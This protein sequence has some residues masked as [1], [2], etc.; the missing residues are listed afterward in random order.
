MKCDRKRFS[1][2]VPGR[3]G[4]PRSRPQRAPGE[5]VP[6]GGEYG[7]RDLPEAGYQAL[8]AGRD[9]RGHVTGR[10]WEEPGD[11]EE[12]I[13]L[14]VAQLE[15]PGQRRRDLGGRPPGASLLQAHEV[16]D[17]H[18]GQRGEFLTPQARRPPR[19][20]GGKPHVD[21]REA[22]APR[23]QQRSEVTPRIPHRPSLT[24]TAGS[25]VV[26]P[27]PLLSR[28]WIIRRGRRRLRA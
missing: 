24:V 1:R 11:D 9:V 28:A 25:W 10:G 12:V 2:P 17:A 20:A 27:V 21:G 15:R 3:A 19:I 5:E 6:R 13:P 7:Q 26:L 8:H 18:I 22:V 23:A 16:V 14:G 4:S